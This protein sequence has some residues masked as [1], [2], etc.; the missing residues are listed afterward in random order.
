MHVE[1]YIGTALDLRVDRDIR[2]L[3]KEN[4]NQLLGI[5]LSNQVKM[6]GFESAN[7]IT[8][9]GK[10]SWNKTNGMLSIWILSMLNASEKTM[11]VAPFKQDAEGPV[12]TDDYFGKVPAVRLRHENGV[13]FLRPMPNIEVKLVFLRLGLCHLLEVMMRKNRC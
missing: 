6:V 1:N 12:Y 11:V 3:G 13:I 4:I 10:I 8:N 7:S 5:N 9:T 2:L